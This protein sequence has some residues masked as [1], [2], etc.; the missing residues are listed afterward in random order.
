MAGAWI[1]AAVWTTPGMKAHLLEGSPDWGLTWRADRM[2]AGWWTFETQSSVE[3]RKRHPE[4]NDI[5]LATLP[6]VQFQSIPPKV[7]APDLVDQAPLNRGQCMVVVAGWPL[8]SF[9]TQ[10]TMARNPTNA[11]PRMIPVVESGDLLRDVLPAGL[12]TRLSLRDGNIVPYGVLWRG[13]IVNAV[14]WSIPFAILLLGLAPLRT[15]VRLR[16]RRC[17]ACGYDLSAS[18]NGVCPECG[19]G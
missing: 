1:G 16:R 2:F 19:P 9:G 13:A 10:Y 14:V 11:M 5:D 4:I 18:P 8:R 15:V 17:V 3:T 6:I 7:R 12:L